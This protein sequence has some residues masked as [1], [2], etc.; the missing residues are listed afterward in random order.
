[1]EDFSQLSDPQRHTGYDTWVGEP[2]IKLSGDWRQ[3]VAISGA[4][5]KNAPILL[6]DEATSAL[7]SEVEVAIQARLSIMIVKEM[8]QR[9]PGIGIQWKNACVIGVTT[10]PCVR[11]CPE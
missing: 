8:R 10:G 2:G 7:D 11:F 3:R 1:M 5:L 4:R 6:L 9:A